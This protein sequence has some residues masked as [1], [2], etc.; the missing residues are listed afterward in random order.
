MTGLILRDYQQKMI[1]DAREAMRRNRSILMVGP[2][3]AGKTA[4]TVTMMAGAASKGI[5]SMFCVHRGTLLLQTSRALWRQ[6]VEHGVVASGRTMSQNPVQVASVQTLVNRLDRVSP[7][8]LIIIDEAHRAAANTYHKILAAYPNAY[9]IGLTAT[10]QRT[11]GKPLS[12]LFDEMVEGPSVAELIRDG[13][14]CDYEIAAPTVGAQFDDIK[15]RAGEF[16]AEDVERAMDKPSITGDAVQHYKRLAYGKRAVVFC[17]TVA[18]SI[19]VRDAYRDA[20]I[21]AEHMDATTPDNEREAMLARLATGET[22]VLCNVE[23]VIEGIDVPMVE[24]IQWLRPTASLI[25]WAQGNGR[26]FRPA[27]GKDKLLILDHVENWK[28]HGLPDD[29]REWSLMGKEK[30]KSKKKQTDEQDEKIKQCPECWH[31]F[32]PAPVCP[33][34]GHIMATGGR[35]IETVEGELAIVDKT[36]AR[37]QQKLEQG[38][39]KTLPELIEIGIRRGMRKPGEWATI[40]IAARQGRKPSHAEFQ[41]ARDYLR[42][43]GQAVEQTETAA[44][45]FF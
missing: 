7:P 11:D 15:V 8:G 28:R 1:D 27:D 26:G 39:A 5:K 3:G 2:T 20:G 29:E 40:T 23:L 4:L 17:A 38:Q 37:K 19:H 44:S 31:V 30:G 32:R 10:P 45:D 21:P 43:R 25:I 41:A 6:K 12:G 9:V 33:S 36:I 14:L 18:H 13:W 35:I 22:L 42:L 24:C 34:C 16:A